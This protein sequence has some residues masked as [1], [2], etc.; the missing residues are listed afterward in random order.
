MD[1]EVTLKEAVRG[2]SCVLSIND[3]VACTECVDLKPIHRMQCA[4]CKGVSYTFAERRVEVSLPPGLQPG[5]EIRYTEFG[6][7]NLASGKNSDL[8]VKIAI[9]EHPVLKID[10]KNIV[11]T[12][13]VPLYDAVLG[14]E[15]EIPTAT[16]KVVMKLQPLT[17]SGKVYRLKG[18]GL[19]GGDQMVTIHIVMPEKLTKE[20]SQLFHKIKAIEQGII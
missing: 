18:L 20:Q 16:G 13:P 7:Y 9:K 4:K 15:L 5:Q 14:T 6:R 10:G 19:P 11:C 12:V 3:P 8:I 1:A 17:P 2:A